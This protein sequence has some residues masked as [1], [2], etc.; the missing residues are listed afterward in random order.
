[1]NELLSLSTIDIIMVILQNSSAKLIATI[2]VW[3]NSSRSLL[4]KYIDIIL[5]KFPKLQMSGP[6]SRGGHEFY[7]YY[8]LISALRIIIEIEIEM[9]GTREI[10]E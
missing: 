4:S 3:M 1:M 6:D 8:A 5:K 10:A 9:K 7:A 2:L